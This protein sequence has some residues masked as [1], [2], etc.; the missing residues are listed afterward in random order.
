[1]KIK[2]L[3][4]I[5][6]ALFG[7]ACSVNKLISDAD[8]S[9]KRKEF[10]DAAEKFRQ[11]NQK[12]KDKTIKPAIYFK[13]AESYRESG[14]YTKAAVWYR[15]AIRSGYKDSTLEIHYA[16]ALRSAGKPEEAKLI[17]E[18]EFKKDSKN[19]HAINGLESVRRIQEWKEIPE[20]Y[21]V[22]N[23]KTI[24]SAANDMV[25][26]IMPG[27]EKS[28][29]IKS[30]REDVP[31]KKINPVTGQKFA[32]FFQS[33]NDTIKMRW[34]IPELLNEPI[35]LNS[36]DEEL[37]L[38][39]S[40]S[41]ELVVFS[42]SVS[43]PTQQATSQLLFFQKKKGQWT[44]PAPLPFTAD[45]ANYLQPMISENGKTLWFASDRSGG[46]GGFDIWKSE[47]ND[48]GIFSE[49]I[50]AGAEINTPGNELYPFE[51]PNG[52]FY[53]S[54]DFHPGMGGFDIFQAQKSG[55]KW[56]I[57][58]LPPPVNS[59]GDDFSIQFFGN[60]EKGFFTSNRKGSR[61]TDAYSFYLPPKL[62]QCFG[63]IHDSE[64][65]SI[66]PDVNI[67]IVG[68]DGSSQ[69][70]RSV[71]GRFQAS[72][73]PE[74]DYAIVVF[75]NGYLNAQAKVS[76]RGLREAKEFEVD[77]KPIPTNKPIRID[78][79]NYELGKWDLLPQAKTSLDKLVELL[80]LNPEA[81]IELSAH[82]D[83]IGDEKFNLELSEKRA[84]SVA[85][86]LT[87][88]G[89]QD[90]NLKAKGYGEAVPLKIN[91]KLARQYEFL[92]E[93]D[94]LSAT[95][96]EKLGGDNLK[97]LARGLN[98]RTEFKVINTVTAK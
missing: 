17:Y 12:V 30:S 86:Y 35:S 19:L 32:D 4:L 29:F 11:A 20:L 95:T 44:S 33:V 73:N 62:F 93:G 87:G 72:L 45:G 55:G 1:M 21:I 67:R 81:I 94:V 68:S 66:L 57:E 41:K 23:L 51:K 56:Q 28:I 39:F 98:R 40:P 59:I 92:N 85:Q 43:N 50:N 48:T 37:F 47:I 27:T 52:Y 79:I 6:V 15:N 97:E 74:S 16:D 64:T 34:N 63:K 14:D 80:K 3:I 10:F 36:T 90:K 8:A 5:A 26:Q 82:T 2:F 78:N 13:L 61:G 83:D 77:I 70:I 38:N 25:V 89:I 71:N 60:L 84:A 88:K 91:A 24:N 9:F 69:K 18:S 7:S 49:P 31:N 58:Q 22:E 96:I 54:S 53:F 76:T 46:L 75:A 42:R 65:D